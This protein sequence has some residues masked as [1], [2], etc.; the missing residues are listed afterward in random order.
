MLNFIP[1]HLDVF[2]SW[3]RLLLIVV[4]GLSLLLFNLAACL[5]LLQ[6]KSMQ[7][8]LRWIFGAIKKIGG[9]LQ[10]LAVDPHRY[11]KIERALGYGTVVVF[12]SLSIILFIYF[13]VFVL[14]ASSKHLSFVQQL[15]V[16]SFSFV[17]VFAAAVFKAEAGRCRLAL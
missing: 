5:K 3:L 2:P 6:S 4:W 17:Y 10:R 7:A 14:L 8:A 11:P 16:L 12:Y 9:Q 13:T 1:E 15:G